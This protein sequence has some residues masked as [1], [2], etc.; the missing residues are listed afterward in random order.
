MSIKL[1]LRVHIEYR[2]ERPSVLYLVVKATQGNLR[3]ELIDLPCFDRPVRL[4]W[5]KHLWICTYVN[6]PAPSWGNIDSQIAAP[7]LKLTD[8]AGRFAT[9]AV[10][11]DSRSVAREFDCD[12]HTVNDSVCA[13]GAPLV[14][15]EN[16]FGDVIA[17]GLDET[18]F[19]RKGPYHT[20][21]WSTSI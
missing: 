5:H 18:L 15:D 16:R 7:R 9:R 13:Y 6:C 8:R 20:Q 2:G 4:I 19:Y 14:G 10:E 11:Q 3:L 17:L 21:Q 12:W 1:P